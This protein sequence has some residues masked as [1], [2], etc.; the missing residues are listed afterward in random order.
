MDLNLERACEPK[1]RR[2]LRSAIAYQAAEIYLAKHRV[3]HD[4]RAIALS[5]SN[6]LPLVLVGANDDTEL[7]A[8]WGALGDGER[9]RYRQDLDSLR[10]DA[11]CVTQ[12]LELDKSTLYLT[13]IG[14]GDG[15]GATIEADLLRIFSAVGVA[16]VREVLD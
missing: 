1:N 12:R 4:M 5:D 6:G 14:N 13:A 8:L 16:S 2:Q 7:L 10:E 9:E 3:L 11:I 15:F